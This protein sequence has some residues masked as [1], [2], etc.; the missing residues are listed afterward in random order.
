MSHSKDQQDQQDQQSDL[1]LHAVCSSWLGHGGLHDARWL[2]CS[3]VGLTASLAQEPQEP[4]EPREPQEVKIHVEWELSGIP[5]CR[6]LSVVF[7]KP[8]T[9][10]VE[11]RTIFE[12]HLRARLAPTVQATTNKSPLEML[13]QRDLHWFADGHVDLFS[14]TSKTS[15]ESIAMMLKQLDGKVVWITTTHPAD[16][17]MRTRAL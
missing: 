12:Q 1:T 9:S 16:A 8:P 2:L 14:D 5:I 3:A 15:Q 13:M 11:V 4:Q 17:I 7:L 10:M 6:A